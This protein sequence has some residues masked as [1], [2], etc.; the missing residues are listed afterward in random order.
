M[1]KWKKT[2][3]NMNTKKM[4][5]KEERKKREWEKWKQHRWGRSWKIQLS[6]ARTVMLRQITITAQ[7]R[8]KYLFSTISPKNL[9]LIV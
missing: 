2:N 5:T 8:F 3:K 7:I 1:K 6:L 9:A 4:I